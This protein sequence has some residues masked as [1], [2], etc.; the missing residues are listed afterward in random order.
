MSLKK[1]LAGYGAWKLFGGCS[2]IL[3]IIGILVFLFIL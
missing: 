1:I 2:G 3:I